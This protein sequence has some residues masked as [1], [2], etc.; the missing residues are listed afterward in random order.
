MATRFALE[1]DPCCFAFTD[2]KSTPDVVLDRF[3][4]PSPWW[5]LVEESRCSPR[6]FP[7]QASALRLGDLINS[8]QLACALYLHR[9]C[10]L[11]LRGLIHKPGRVVLSQ[12]HWDVMFDIDRTD[13]RLR[14]VALDSD[15]GWV[16]WLG[17]V[18]RFHYDSDG[19][20]HV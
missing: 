2:T 17:R 9:H 6:Y 7:L 16:P 8:F 5:R 20:D 15:P 4:A 11:S 10:G 12:T 3:D 19:R 13:L 18:L 1:D 14:R